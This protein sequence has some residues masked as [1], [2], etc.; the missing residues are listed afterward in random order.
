VAL[1]T[2]SQLRADCGPAGDNCPKRDANDIRRLHTAATLSTV[3]LIVGGVGMAGGLTL[4]VLAPAK[5]PE[6]KLRLGLGLGGLSL[7]GEL[8]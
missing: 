5:A 6:R 7:R 4:W 1:A 8:R 2:R 3:A